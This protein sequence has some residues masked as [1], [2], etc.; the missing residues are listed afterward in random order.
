LASSS[1]S[2][3]PLRSCITHHLIQTSIVLISLTPKSHEDMNNQMHRV[4]HQ[5][6]V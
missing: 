2:A 6:Y 4:E 3:R 5:Q 1:G